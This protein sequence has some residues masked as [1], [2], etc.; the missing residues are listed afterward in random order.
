MPQQDS[1][2]LHGTS[3][4]FEHFAGEND[5]IPSECY[6]SRARN[7]KETELT[8]IAFVTLFAIRLLLPNLSTLAQAVVMVAATA[9][10]KDPLST[11]TSTPTNGDKKI[12]ISSS[13]KENGGN[14]FRRKRSK[15]H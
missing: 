4:D 14:A 7:R 5:A 3:S 1:K 11:T 15:M 2:R 13:T 6:N 10:S 9:Y 8:F 12:D